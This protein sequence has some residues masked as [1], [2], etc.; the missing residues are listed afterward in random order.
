M[1]DGTA[2]EDATWAPPT[3]PLA[4][5]KQELERGSNWLGLAD[6]GRLVLPRRK[7]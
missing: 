1:A 7:A 3:A 2:M 5:P 6:L 4:M